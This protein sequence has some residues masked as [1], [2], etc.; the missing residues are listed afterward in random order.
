MVAL[1]I[2]GV[3]VTG[4]VVGTLIPWRLGLALRARGDA[5]GAWAVAG[6]AELLAFAATGAAARGTPMIVELRA[7]GRSLLRRLFP[8]DGPPPPPKAP[9]KPEPKVSLVERYRRL[10]RVA[11]PVDLLIFLVSE[12]RRLSV[13]D[14]EASVCLGLA[15]AALAGEIAG[16]LMVISALS[17]PFGRLDHQIDWSGREHVEASLSLSL[18]FSPALLVWDTARFLARAQWQRRFPREIKGHVPAQRT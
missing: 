17:S 14:V 1:L 6:G 7:F 11:D 10:S 13:R 4:L 2:T 5:Q 16:V 12:R 15:D 9:A 18:R 3:V 8:P